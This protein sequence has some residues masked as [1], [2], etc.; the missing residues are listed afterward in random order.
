MIKP[1]GSQATKRQLGAHTSPEVDQQSP[2]TL[3]VPFGATE[4]HGPHLPLDTDTRIAEELAGRVAAAMPDALV[5]P[6]ISIG[7]SGEHKGFAGTLSIGTDVLVSVLVEI[8]RTAGPEVVR[9]AVVNAHGGNVE[10]I[11][12]ACRICA[13]EGRELVAWTVR[14]PGSDAHAGRTETSLMLA[15][16]PDLVRLDLLEPG[17]TDPIQNLLPELRHHG[18][19]GVTANGVLGD[20]TGATAQEGRTLLGRLLTDAVQS[21][22]LH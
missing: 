11:D 14:I 8:V 15:I 7:A 5:G 12:K 10:A 1:P 19:A 16:A 18:L 3:V 2:F 20:P 22:K 21:L 4:Q 17:V 9:V 6:T 13:S